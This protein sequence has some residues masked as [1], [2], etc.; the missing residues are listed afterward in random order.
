MTVA[1]EGLA[2]H[3]TLVELDGE[4]GAVWTAVIAGDAEALAE[5]ILTFEM[6][7]KTAAEVL[8]GT[9]ATDV[10]RAFRTIVK[11]RVNRGGILAPGAGIFKR[12]ENGKGLTSRWYPETLARRIRDITSIR[13]R[14]T[15][16]AGDGIE[17]LHNYAD[18]KD[19]VAFIDPSYTAGGKSAGSRLYTHWQLDHDALFRAAGPFKGDVLLTYE[20]SAEVRNLA[21]TYGFETR[22][23][24]MK[25]THHAKM[26]EL[27][28]GRDLRWLDAVV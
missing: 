27:L 23:V 22:A 5:R 1:A 4:V 25:N 13:D 28:I 19:A 10:D 3:V 9:P 26:K 18:E 24:A 20:N 2:K 21:A 12:G 17:A 8:A 11:N 16:I 15:F 6:G 7:D 14:L